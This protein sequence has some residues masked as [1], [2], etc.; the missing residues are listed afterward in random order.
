M[1]LASN[2]RL[3]TLLWGQGACLRRLSSTCVSL[4]VSQSC[5]PPRPV[6]EVTFL[7]YVDDVRTSLETNIRASTACYEIALLLFF[8]N[9]VPP[10]C[11]R[12]KNRYGIAT[13]TWAVSAQ[14]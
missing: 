5:G 10:S 1:T 4:E 2:Y 14:G 6:T 13:A 9:F 8:L 12:E 3:D 11:T 7:F